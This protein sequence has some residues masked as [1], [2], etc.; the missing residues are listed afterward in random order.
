[1]TPI[2]QGEEEMA[3]KLPFAR[4]SSKL[5]KHGAQ[6]EDIRTIQIPWFSEQ[7]FDRQLRILGFLLMVFLIIAA[8]FTYLDTRTAS[9]SSRYV[10]QASK[11]QLLSQRVAK[12]AEVASI[13]GENDAFDALLDAR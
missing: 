4:S 7:S 9:V 11:L 6:K 12:F 2:A 13:S 3:F 1:M 10:A 8:V 5:A